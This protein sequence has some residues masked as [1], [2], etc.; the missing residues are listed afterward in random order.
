MK[1]TRTKAGTYTTVIALRDADGKRHIKRFTA[2][3]RREVQTMALE[4]QVTARE[5]IDSKAFGDCLERLLDKKDKV[6]SPSTMRGYRNYQRVLVREYDAFMRTPIDRITRNQIQELANSLRETKKEKTVKNYIALISST[7]EENGIH[8]PRTTIRKDVQKFEANVPNIEVVRRVSEEVKGTEWELPFGLACM[9]LRRSEIKGVRSEDLSKENVLHIRRAVVEGG[10]HRMLYEKTTK[11]DKSDR[12]ILIPDQ[13][14]DLLRKQGVA[15]RRSP[16]SMTDNFHT[17]L[18]HA[19]V[20][21]FRLHDCRHFFASYCHE[22]LRL[23]DVQIQKLGG[24]KTDHVM[25]RV[26]ITAITDETKS[27]QSAFGGL[28]K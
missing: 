27:V 17:V 14:A 4:Y 12:Y 28:L 21:D 3:T 24:W 9:G 25:K 5:Y 26:Y 19:G 23:S 22:V 18:R 11:T 1:I 2:K 13:L 15:W 20:H 7:L 10:E 16:Q 8:K 6:L